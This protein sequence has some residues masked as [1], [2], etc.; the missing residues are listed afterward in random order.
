MKKWAK[1][2]AVVLVIL[3]GAWM[4]FS[5]F[6]ILAEQTEGR[7]DRD[8][9]RGQVSVLEGKQKANTKALREANRRLR[10]AGKAPVEIPDPVGSDGE[11]QEP[12]IQE[13]EVQ[14]PDRDD[15]EGQ[16]AENDDP[17]VQDDEVQDGEVDDPD[18]NDPDPDDP[19]P[20]DPDPDDPDPNDP[21]P[22]DPDPGLT[23]TYGC[24][25]PQFVRS[26]TFQADGGVTVVCASPTVV[27]DPGP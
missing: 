11:I 2:T 8:T 25:P 26:I 6:R 13:R 17:E 19:D 1:W 23:G 24:E 7:A 9:L 3:V 20:N 4:L 18:P 21:D 15:P 10:A 27:P 22:D 14:D 16:D 5:V 12:E